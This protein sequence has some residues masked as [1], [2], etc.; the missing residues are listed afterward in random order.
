MDDSKTLFDS[1]NVNYNNITDEDLI[2]I[3]KSG[4]TRCS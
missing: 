3:I 1:I 2:R 4:D